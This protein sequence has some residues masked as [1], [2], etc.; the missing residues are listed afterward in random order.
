MSVLTPATAAWRFFDTEVAAVTRLS[1]SFVRLTLAGPDLAAFADNGWDQ[2]FKLVLPDVRG[3][4]D[5]LPR[6]ADWYPAWRRLPADQQNPVR[7]YTVRAVRPVEREV[8]V[9][10]VLH[11][12]S[13]PASRFARRAVVGDPLVVLGPNAEY[14]DVHGGLEFRPPP[15]H[16]GPTLLVGD[17]TATP[18][19]LSVVDRLPDAAHGEAVLEVPHPGDILPVKA[20]VG[21]RVTWLIRRGPCSGL[22]SAVD[23]ALRRLGIRPHCDSDVPVPEAVL[24]ETLWDVPEHASAGGLYVW[25]AGESAL[26]TGLRRQLVRDRGVDRRSVAFM[27][28]WRE[29]APAG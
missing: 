27:G 11:G 15:G 22:P 12:D 13:G 17:A 1:P 3:S 7:T 25:I 16:L 10:L 4:F 26:V 8:D 19:V 24:G 20:P 23:T 9:D 18:A 29:G 6:H 14:D 28:Y 5:S 21:F 2:R